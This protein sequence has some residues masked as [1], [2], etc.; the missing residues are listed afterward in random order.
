MFSTSTDAILL[1]KNSA[2]IPLIYLKRDSWINFCVDTEDFFRYCFQEKI[3]NNVEEIALGAHCKIKRIFSMKKSNLLRKHFELGE[4]FNK[5]QDEILYTNQIYTVDKIEKNSYDKRLELKII[6]IE[7]SLVGFTFRGRRNTH[8]TPEPEM[9]FNKSNKR[10]F[11]S[12]NKK[13]NFTNAN[14]KSFEHKDSFL[15]GKLKPPNHLRIPSV[16][17]SCSPFVPCSGKNT[18]KISDIMKRKLSIDKSNLNCQK[19]IHRNNIFLNQDHKTQHFTNKAVT[20]KNIRFDE[21]ETFMKKSDN[22]LNYVCSNKR[23]NKKNT[24]QYSNVEDKL[25]EKIMK[26]KEILKEDNSVKKIIKKVPNENITKTFDNRKSENIRLKSMK[27]YYHKDTKSV[28]INNSIS[29]VK[30]CLRPIKKV[31]PE[32]E[33]KLANL[34]NDNSILLRPFSPPFTQLPSNVVGN[35]INE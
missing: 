33:V 15:V 4:V 3:Y 6:R 26:Y 31:N 24:R 9:I 17:F 34:M 12:I 23:V 20:I 1:N 8:K 19:I 5:Y 35:N 11:D 16:K 30:K 13:V 27:K 22:N 28:I 2:K 25:K 18:A 14:N 32:D 21:D 10:V 7:P 29:N